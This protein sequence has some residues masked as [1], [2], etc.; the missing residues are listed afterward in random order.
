MM[1]PRSAKIINDTVCKASER[2]S[3]VVGL[4]P[5][6]FEGEKKIEKVDRMFDHPVRI[7]PKRTRDDYSEFC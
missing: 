1:S 3:V 2:D 4:M 6:K 7:R 5:A